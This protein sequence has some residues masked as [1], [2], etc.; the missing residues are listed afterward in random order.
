MKKFL[1]IFV[2]LVCSGAS[3]E[4][5]RD[6]DQGINPTI[7]GKVVY[8]LG[9]QNCIGA[10]CLTQVFKEY[11]RCLDVRKVLEFSCQAGKVVETELNCTAEQLCRAG[12]CVKK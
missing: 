12:I 10:D 6:S 3:A 9:E 4:T 7:A 2:L 1:A 11:D 5:C 8:S